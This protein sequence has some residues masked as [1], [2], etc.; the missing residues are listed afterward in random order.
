M[1]NLNLKANLKKLIN[2]FR[3]LKRYEVFLFIIFF[4][5][6]YGFLIFRI[7]RLSSMEP[8]DDAVSEKLQTVKRPKIDQA[9]I[10]K[11]QQLQDQ[12]VEVKSLFDQARSNPFAE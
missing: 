7:N 3:G 11:I 2:F 8:S 5:L 12:N 9:S 6:L 10:D 1:K 4:A